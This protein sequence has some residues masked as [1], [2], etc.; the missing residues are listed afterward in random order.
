M[1]SH[2]DEEVSSWVEVLR[3][4][5]VLPL[6]PSMSVSDDGYDEE[7]IEDLV[8]WTAPPSPPPSPSFMHPTGVGFLY[9][10]GRNVVVAVRR[11]ADGPV[12]GTSGWLSREGPQHL[13][14]A[15]RGRIANLDDL[16]DRDSD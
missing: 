16:L 13:I 15:R 6:P 5:D 14:T 4:R 11:G 10:G 7:D 8:E 1:G 3:L 2:R 9:L 12:E